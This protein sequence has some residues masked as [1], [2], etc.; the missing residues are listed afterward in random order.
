MSCTRQAIEYLASSV[1]AVRTEHRRP[2]LFEATVLL[3]PSGSQTVF[4][5][6]HNNTAG[7]LIRTIPTASVTDCSEHC[8]RSN[9]IVDEYYSFTSAKVI[10]YVRL[11]SDRV[12][13]SPFH[14]DVFKQK[15]LVGFAREVVPAEDIQ[16]CMSACLNSFD[17]FGFEC[18]SAMYYPVDQECILNTEDRLDRPDLFADE[19][20]DTVIYMDNNCAGSQC[21]APYITQYI[22]VDGNQLENE[23][24][25]II[26]V[27]VDSCQSLC[28]QRLSLTVNDFNCKSFMYNNQTRTCILSDE[29]SKPLGRGTLIK[30]EGFTYY[31]KKCF[32]SPNTCRNVPSFTRVPQM[33]LV[34]FAAFVMENVPSVTM[35]LDQCTNPPPETGDN[36]ECKSVMYYYNEQ[37]CILN[38]ET[39]HSKPDLF[40]PE[41]DEFQVDYFD[42]TCHLKEENCS[43]GTHLK[44]VRT[45]NAALPEGEGDLHVLKS[46][47][48]GIKE[49]IKKCFGSSPEKCRSFNYDKR[50]GICNLLY[51]D[52][53]NT[54]RPRIRQGTDFYEMHCLAAMPLVEGDCSANKD[55]VLFSRYLHTKQRGIASKTYKV[56]SL[57]SCLEVCAGNPVCAGVN[58]NRRFGQC[59]VFD[60]I[61]ESAD[62]NE[63]VDFYKNLCVVKEIDSDISA[64]ANVPAQPHRMSGTVTNKKD[65]RG[66]LL[67][68]KKV[69][70]KWN[71]NGVVNFGNAIAIMTCTSSHYF[72]IKPSIREHM[73]RRKPES[74]IHL[75]PPVSIPADAIQTICNY[76]GIRVQVNHDSSFNGVIFVK[77][78]YDTCRVE[79]ANSKSAILVLGLPKD[80]GM[81]PITLDG[82]DEMTTDSV[83]NSAKAE[84]IKDEHEE[85]RHKRQADSRDCGLIDMLNGTYKTTVVI[86][87][88]NLGIPGLVTSMDQLY[89]VSCDYSSMLGG[90]VQAGYNMTVLGPEANLIQ[91]RGKIELGN[92][93][94]MQLVSSHGEQPVVQAKL[95][96]ILELRWEIMAMDDEL[97][98][99]V[100]DC[101]A[102]PGVGAKAEEKLQLIQGGCPTAAVAVKLIPGPIEVQSTSVKVARMQAFRFDSSSSIRIT[103]EVDICKG[104]CT[105]V[106]CGLTEGQRHSW[107]RKKRESENSVLEYETSRYIV[108]KHVR[109]TTSIVIIDP[110]QQIQ[111]P[112]SLARSSTIEFLR[113][114]AEEIA[115][116]TTGQMCMAKPTLL[117]V[118]G[119]LLTLTSVQA[120]VVIQH[121]VRRLC[122]SSKL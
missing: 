33:I 107:G 122:R 98:F 17:T 19:F 113:E 37:E 89:E 73:H 60:A 79:V 74:T 3:C 55:D 53:M 48:K 72:Q 94:F 80:F 15:I 36:F 61:D 6:Q 83:K 26:N 43:V 76:E 96:D 85:F 35:C 66:E 39:R 57:T 47:G 67:A 119:F 62:A 77:N 117:A 63:H 1:S 31:E 101:F 106:E 8:A 88:N 7:K 13:S 40:I 25:R 56:V 92:P 68:T 5:L 34:G 102:E 93:V 46:A 38:A 97:D 65:A 108:P 28:T 84:L 75:G 71:L 114:E 18:E 90:K 64:A 111:E 24:D 30:T 14:F 105:P 49:C 54:L 9:L 12:C 16:V 29:R 10:S 59:D 87:T 69:I 4:L 51:L 50:S 21:Y 82:I 2:H 22:A 45:I 42:I 116:S 95:G 103:C 120:I 20:E 112:V 41:G 70:F 104:D 115:V 100:K 27:D 78:K 121:V 118:F 32:A 86:Q 11:Q 91:P 99:F 58:Y 81:R 44:A 52:S 109:A 110:L 23:L